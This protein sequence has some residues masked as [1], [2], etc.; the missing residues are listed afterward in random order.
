VSGE[1][2]VNINPFFAESIEPGIPLFIEIDGQ[3][4]PFFVGESEQIADDICIVKFIF[5][6]TLEEA[7]KVCGLRVFTSLAQD[8]DTVYEGDLHEL[9]GFTVKDEKA[10]V[11]GVVL[12]VAG[13]SINP[14]LEIQK[15]KEICLAPVGGPFIVRVDRNNRILITRLP[16][17]IPGLTD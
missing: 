15:D 5:I 3:R 11:L 6:D 4:V 9:T 12:G 1:L 8:S 14:L 2:R 10:G 13:N 16:D 7:K 17:G